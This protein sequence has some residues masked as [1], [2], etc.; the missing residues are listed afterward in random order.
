MIGHPS[1]CEPRKLPQNLAKADA[2][3]SFCGL[4]YPLLGPEHTL[5]MNAQE[6]VIAA[7]QYALPQ[8]LASL[9]AGNGFCPCSPGA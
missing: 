2:S 3:I 9:G 8:E 5:G 6:G 1:V 7:A 4:P